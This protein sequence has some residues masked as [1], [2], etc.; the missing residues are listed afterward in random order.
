MIEFFDSLAHDRL[1]TAQYNHV[2]I[3]GDECGFCMDAPEYVPAGATARYE[4]CASDAPF[5]SQSRAFR[6]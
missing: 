1:T 6:E 5:A 4:G 3:I 2:N